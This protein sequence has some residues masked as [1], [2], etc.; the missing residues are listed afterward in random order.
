MYYIKAELKDIERITNLVKETIYTTY[1]KYYPEE[2]IEFFVEHHRAENIEKDIKA[3]RVW[4]LLNESKELV[5]T[6][7]YVEN[8]VTRL[9]IA[10]KHQRKGYGSYIMD[11]IEAEIAKNYDWCQLDAS[12]P[13]SQVYEKRGYH[14][15]KHDEHQVANGV[16]LVYEIME[17]PLSRNCENISYNGRTFTTKENTANGEVDNHTIFH[18]HQEERTI[19]AEYEGGIIE[20]GFLVGQVK[21][22]GKL[23]FTYQHLNKQGEIKL[24][25]CTSFPHI[26]PDGKLEMHESWQWLGQDQAKG[27]SIL[28]EL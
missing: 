20:K 11:K 17:K 22:E 9:Y 10:P 18:Y 25:K 1:S 3:N 19:W 7:S 5:G 27:V 13:A 6:G 15:I 24:G 2:V 8:Y 14:T 16:I 28:R 21:E 26:L 23:E 12:L 4:M